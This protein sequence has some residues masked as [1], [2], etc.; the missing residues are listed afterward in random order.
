MQEGDFVKLEDKIWVITKI[1]DEDPVEPNIQL[2]CH[3]HDAIR[4]VYPNE[5]V[6]VFESSQIPEG[7]CT[8]GSIVHYR[9]I[10]HPSAHGVVLM[11]KGHRRLVGWRSDE[12]EPFACKSWMF[13]SELQAINTDLA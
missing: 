12:G 7:V 1:D 4:W 13:I 8:C 3:D 10:E 9:G 5:P 11:E 6:L 2:Y